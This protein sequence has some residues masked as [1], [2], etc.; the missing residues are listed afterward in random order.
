MKTSC[1][2]IDDEP[3]ALKLLEEYVSKVPS[4]ELRG[5]FF[6]ALEAFDFLKREQIDIIVTDINM[7]ILSGL[8]L[9]AI[10][11]KLQKFIFTTAYAEHALNSFNFRVIDY[12]LKPIE[13]PRFLKAIDKIELDGDP[14][15]KNKVAGFNNDSVFV[16]SSGQVIKIVISEILYIK[17]EK[18]YVS[19]HFAEKR[20]LIYKR[21]KEMEALLPDSFKRIHVSFIVNT[22]HIQ[23]VVDNH[24]VIGSEKIPISEG[25]R[26]K[27]LGILKRQMI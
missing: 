7:P 24:V 9:A 6:D 1:I 8:E 19:L 16:K 23:K 12:L 3:H 22:G 5:Q 21:M 13:F 2:L 10:L 26:E 17:G 20:L 11:P 27:F 4:L 15:Q 18:E 25:Y 14:F